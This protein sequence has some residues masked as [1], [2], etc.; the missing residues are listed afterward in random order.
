MLKRLFHPDAVAGNGDPKPKEPK[1]AKEPKQPEAK[2]EPPA[3]AKVVAN[4]KSERE[5][6]LENELEAE[7]QRVAAE[8]ARTKKLETDVAHLQDETRALKE[9]G[10]TKEPAKEPTEAK[11]SWFFKD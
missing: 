6:Q 3:A 2:P 11:S 8:K 5:I 7:R 10:L 1:E 4:G 9:A